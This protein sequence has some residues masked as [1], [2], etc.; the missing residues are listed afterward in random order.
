MN[1]TGAIEKSVNLAKKLGLEAI[2]SVE[3]F[4]PDGLENIVK[5]MIDRE[6]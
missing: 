3:K 5:S 6:F 4:N 1:E 2:K